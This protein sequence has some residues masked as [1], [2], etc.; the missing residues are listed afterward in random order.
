MMRKLAMCCAVLALSAVA[1]AQAGGAAPAAPAPSTSLAPPVKVGI[2]NIQLAIAFSNEGQ[3]DF[4]ALQKKFEPKQNE[5]TTLNKEVEDLKKQLQA[6]AN[7]GSDES[8]ANLARTIEQKQKILQRNAEDAQSDYR[9]QQNELAG[10]I[11]NKM[12]GVLDKYAKENGF[13]VVLNYDEQNPQNP[14]LWAGASVDITRPVL[15]AYNIISGVPAPPPPAPSAA[16]PGAGTGGGTAAVP[17]RPAG[18][19]PPPKPAGS[20][21]PR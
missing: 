7:V 11:G 2:I 16:K 5:I 12:L 21:P 14:I 1:V 10:K 15:E 17:S 19:N 9:A 20:N 18:T 4:A 6:Q 3:R 8:R 13:A